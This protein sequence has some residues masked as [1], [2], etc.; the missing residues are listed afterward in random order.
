MQQTAFISIII[1]VYNGE[2]KIEKCLSSI[3]R[4]EYPKELLEIIIVDDDSTDNT[5]DVIQQYLPLLKKNGFDVIYKTQ[6]NQG[7]GA[8]VDNALKLFTGDYLCWADPDDYFEPGSFIERVNFL[9]AHPEY[10]IV[11]SDVYI[12]LAEKLSNFE[13]MSRNIP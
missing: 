2:K 5:D 1:P 10:A 11:T 7:V 13:K 9:E 3:V 6:P 4:Q 12:R 8:T